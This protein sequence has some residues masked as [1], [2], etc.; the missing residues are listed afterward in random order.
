MDIKEK[1]QKKRGQ[2]GQKG[3]RRRKM[4]RN[5]DKERK[6]M[7]C[8]NWKKDEGEVKKLDKFTE[9]TLFVLF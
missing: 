3:K 8:Q 9:K 1:R 5:E 7:L 6:R 2:R 4:G